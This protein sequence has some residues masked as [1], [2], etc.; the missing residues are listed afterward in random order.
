MFER[1]EAMGDNPPAGVGL[2]LY[3]VKSLVDLMDGTIQ[4]VSEIGR[5]SCFTVRLPIRLAAA[6]A[7]AS[8]D[9]KKQLNPRAPNIGYAS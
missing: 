6:K 4:L 7:E 2:G 1:V 8:E 5:G 9:P 3:I